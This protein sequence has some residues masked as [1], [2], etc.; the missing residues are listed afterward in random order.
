[1]GCPLESVGLYIDGRVFL[2]AQGPTK[3]YKSKR[4]WW[5]KRNGRTK[6][7]S[8]GS[9]TEGAVPYNPCCRT[10]NVWMKLSII[11][12]ICL[13]QRGIYLGTFGF[14]PILLPP[15]HSACVLRVDARL[16]CQVTPFSKHL[17]LFNN[18]FRVQQQ[19]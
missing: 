16:S 18:F 8:V 15:V 6:H 12:L 14:F 5:G 7:L 11:S 1:M 10:L 3:Q 17:M 13:S 9:G 19:M 2:L 4:S